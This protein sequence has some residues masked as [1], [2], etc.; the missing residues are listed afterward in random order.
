M[1][2][3]IWNNLTWFEITF[4]PSVN[5]FILIVSSIWFNRIHQGLMK[6]VRAGGDT[7][8]VVETGTTDYNDESKK[9]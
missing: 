7:R 4:Y 3:L 9:E 8:V 6:V 1:S 2:G 5:V